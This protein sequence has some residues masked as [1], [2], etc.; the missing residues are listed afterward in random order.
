MVAN[1]TGTRWNERVVARGL[2]WDRR[3]PARRATACPRAGSMN[4][5][6][7]MKLKKPNLGP[8]SLVASSLGMPF[9]T[10]TARRPTAHG[11][12]SRSAFSFH[13]SSLNPV[14][15]VLCPASS[16]R[17]LLPSRTQSLE[18]CSPA[19]GV[20]ALACPA[21]ECAVHPDMLKHEP[22]QRH[23]AHHSRTPHPASRIMLGSN[24]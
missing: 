8:W 15:C 11:P 16:T 2:P 10:T 23:P 7:V 12:C 13:P 5:H 18:T 19:V 6:V 24:T 3:A 9:R 1:P 22:Q 21:V 17:T 4:Y 14:S 20:H